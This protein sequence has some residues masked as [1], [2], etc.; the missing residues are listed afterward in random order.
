MNKK[1][2]EAAG[3]LIVTILVIVSFMLIAGTVTQLLAKSED[4]EAEVLCHDSVALRASTALR[5]NPKSD[6]DF[7]LVEA[8][9]KAV[10][11]LCKTID[12]KVKGNKEEVMKTIADKMARCWWM[13]GEGRYEE[14]LH[15]S[16]VRLLPAIF[17]TDKSENKCFVCYTQL[18]E[19]EDFEPITA[20]ELVKYL[21]DTPYPKVKG[22]TYLE[23]FQSSGGPGAVQVLEDIKPRQAYGIS[24]LAK[25]APQEGTAL[26]GVGKLVA[27]ATP[28][29]IAAAALGFTACAASVVCLLAAGAGVA[30]GGTIMYSGTGDV[31]NSL[32]DPAQ[33]EVSM[34]TFDDLT[35]AQQKCFEGDLG[36][37]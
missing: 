5:I 3:Q 6:G 8:Q 9:I 36:G 12:K 18:I 37:E 30:V 7:K 4:K 23:Y 11:A 32:Y 21:V 31:I 14:I 29:P 33:R 35:T 25:N 13:F 24:F 27:G 15:D 1:A 10:P 17:N 20:G 16:D 28:V 34:I 26:G 2:M 22:R 19:E